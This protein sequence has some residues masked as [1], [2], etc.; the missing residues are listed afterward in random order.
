MLHIYTGES[1][2]KTTASIGLAVRARGAGLKVLFISY[3]KPD[4]SSE[5]QELEKL[6]VKVMHMPL[7]GNYFKRYDKKD[8]EEAKKEFA[9]FY[10]DAEAETPEHDVIIHDEI[11]YAANMGLVTVEQLLDYVDRYRDKHEIIFTGRDYPEKLLQKADY[12]T[13]MTKIKH[14]F[15]EGAQ[16]RRGIE[17]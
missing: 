10:V 7:R 11:I 6:G 16:P 13:E 5:H 2:G 9:N 8:L 4:K 17:Y 1:K 14:P 3:F 15:V 12:V